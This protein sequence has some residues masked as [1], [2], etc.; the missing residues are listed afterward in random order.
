MSESE[1]SG[2]SDSS[3][4]S[5][6][7]EEKLQREVIE[8][9]QQ[10]ATAA[11]IFDLRR[12]IGGLFVLYGIIVTIAGITASDAEIA[13]AQGVNINL[14]TGIGMLLLGLFFLAWLKLR[15]TPPPVPHAAPDEERDGAGG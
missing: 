15:P 5:E 13:K 3:E 2:F 11:R 8:L 4:F 9:E 7:S 10:S 1:H 14:W 12:I 6:F